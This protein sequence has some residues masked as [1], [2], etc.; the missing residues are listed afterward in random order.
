MSSGPGTNTGHGHVW[1]RPDGARAR[2]GGPKLCRECALDFTR[3][4]KWGQEMV[5]EVPQPQQGCICPPGSEKTCQGPL[6][7]RRP[8]VAVP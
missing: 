2:C 8:V 7:P 3:W 4:T 6:C 5:W 1:P